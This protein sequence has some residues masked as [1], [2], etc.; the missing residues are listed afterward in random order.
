MPVL[1][2]LALPFQLVVLL[3]PL[4]LDL[5]LFVAGVRLVAWDR[6]FVTSKNGVS[7]G[8]QPAQNARKATIR[9]SCSLT[10]ARL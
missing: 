8:S 2:R 7:V 3:Y 10:V 4:V 6:G 9:A 1:L 5:Q